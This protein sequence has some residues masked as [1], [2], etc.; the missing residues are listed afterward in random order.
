MMTV[1]QQL[2]S[3]KTSLVDHVTTRLTTQEDGRYLR[4]S[5]DNR[6]HRKRDRDVGLYL[7]R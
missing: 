4:H 1:S 7:G 5:N 6:R 3:L 2:K